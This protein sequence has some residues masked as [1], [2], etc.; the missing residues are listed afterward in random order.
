MFVGGFSDR[1]G[2]RLVILIA[3]MTF[4]LG[5]LVMGLAMDQWSLLIG[6]AIAG[7]AI[8][9]AS[10]V[11]PIYIAE[12]APKDIRGSLIT[13]N[14]CFV[15]LG[16]FA[17]SMLAAGCTYLP[18]H[19]GWRVMLGFAGIP[20]ILQFVAFIFMPESPRWLLMKGKDE[21]AFLVLNQIRGDTIAAKSE[22]EEIRLQQQI[23]QQQQRMLAN[24]QL[25][26]VCINHQDQGMI[27]R[28]YGGTGN[29]ASLESIRASMAA[30]IQSERKLTLSNLDRINWPSSGRDMPSLT[31]LDKEEPEVEESAA[32][33]FIRVLKTS[34]TRK[35]LL[36]G[37]ALQMFQQICGINTVMYYSATIIQMSGMCCAFMMPH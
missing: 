10:F 24:A 16:L 37:S 4:T 31:N 1:V 3:S 28:G 11:A 26:H 12:L 6:R 2:R 14:Q 33:K 17:A 22:I 25:S 34:S 7:A 29:S 21:K 5:S 32:A 27:N 23:Q 8:G 36:I 20:S 19:L 9:F 35:A 15:T 13:V 18:E 30:N